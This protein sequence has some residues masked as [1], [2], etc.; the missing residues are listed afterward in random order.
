MYFFMKY[1][2]V[3]KIKASEIREYHA[4]LHMKMYTIQEQTLKFYDIIYTFSFKTT[5][6][7]DFF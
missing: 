3:H 6:N 5:C 2:D 1:S 7:T 4:L